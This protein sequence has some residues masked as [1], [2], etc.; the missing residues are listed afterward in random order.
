MLTDPAEWTRFYATREQIE[1]YYSEFASSYQLPRCTQFQS[2]VKKCVWDEKEMVWYVTVQR[3]GESQLQHWKADVVCQC[4]GSLDRPK[5]GNTPGREKFQGVSWH[6]AHWRN[7]Y[8][9][10]GK[11]VGIIGCGPSAAQ[12]IPEI[13]DK[14]GHMTVYVR[15]PPVCVPRNDFAY[16]RLFRWAVRWIPGFAYLVRLRMNFR[17]MRMGMG[18]ATDNSTGNDGM[19]RTAVQ[20]MESQIIDPELR[21]KLRPDSKCTSPSSPILLG[22]TNA[23]Q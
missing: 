3:R 7:D 1:D 6:T 15:T 13:I 20:F 8:D 9:L 4:V 17:M 12:I 16:S 23:F 11:K 21:E 10:T 5:F 18:L 19:N 2:F 14:V 22:C